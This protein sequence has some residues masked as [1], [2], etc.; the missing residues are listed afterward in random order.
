MKVSDILINESKTTDKKD[1]SAK[2]YKNYVAGNMIFN[3][4][5]SGKMAG[6][7]KTESE[8]QPT[9]LKIYHTDKF[10]NT[11]YDIVFNHKDANRLHK[12]IKKEGGKVT[13]HALMYGTTEGEKKAIN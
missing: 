12:T 9:G 5:C 4:P 8:E 2:R 3:Q 11:G 10:G 6:E 7:I 13:H 1:K